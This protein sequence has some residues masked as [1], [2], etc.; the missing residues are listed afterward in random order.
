MGNVNR[1]EFFGLTIASLLLP[2]GRREP[3]RDVENLQQWARYR[4]QTLRNM[5]EVMGPLPPPPRTS[6]DV[7]E[8]EES[9]LGALTRTEITYR[10]QKGDHV[11]AVLCLH[12]TSPLGAAEPAGLG[13]NPNLHY[14]LEFAERGYVT[15]APDYP[16][17]TAFR[18][19]F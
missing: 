18:K 3:L 2:D 5:E 14:A 10:S 11:P 1:R 6:F 7:R 4:R 19:P 17:C 16:N 12:Q 15:L 13:V 9:D 8:L